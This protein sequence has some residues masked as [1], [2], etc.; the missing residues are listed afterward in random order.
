MKNMIQHAVIFKFNAEISSL[1]KQA[2]F[3]AAKELSQIEGVKNLEVLRQISPKNDFEFGISMVF[4]NAEIY[5]NYT[6]HPNHDLFIQ[7][8]WLKMVESFLEIDYEPLSI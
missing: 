1:E 7:N 4:D 5:H 8:Y 3:T 2:F 6:I